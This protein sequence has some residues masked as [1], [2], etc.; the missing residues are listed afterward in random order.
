MAQHSRK[1][2]RKYWPILFALIPLIGLIAIAVSSSTSDGAPLVNTPTVTA[3]SP[4]SGPATGGTAISITGTGFITGATVTIGQGN[5]SVTG[6]ISATGVTVVSPTEITATTGG[7]AKA[8]TWSLFVTTSGGTSAANVGDN[9]TYNAPSAVPTVTAISPNSGPTTGNTPITITGTGFI[10]GA[11]VT[12]GQGSGAVTG[13]IAATSVTVVSSTKITAVTGGGSKAGTWSLFVTTSGGTSAANTSDNFTY[14]TGGV[15]P[16]VTAVSPNS[17]PTAGGTTVTITGTGFVS[18]ATVVIGQGNGTSGALAATVTSTTSTTITATTGGGAKAG[19]F[20]LYVTTPGGTSA[21][22]AGDS[23]SY[24]AA[25]VKVMPLGDSITDGYLTPG[26][27]RTEL[28]QL[29]VNQDHDNISFVGSENSGALAP[30]DPVAS[31][32]EEGHIGWC[33]GLDNSP[34]TYGQDLSSDIV[35]WLNTYQPNIILLHAGT[36]DIASGDTGAQVTTNMDDFLNQ[37]FTTLPKADVLLAKII[38]I[39]NVQ[40]ESN[41]AAMET[42]WQAYNAAI[43]GLVSKYQGLGFNIQLVDMSDVL[44]PATDYATGAANPQDDDFHPNLA[45]YDI[46]AETWYPFVKAL[47]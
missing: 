17:G 44:N 38:P 35:G 1:L 32:N 9:F 4:N 27:Y 3:V 18:G 6:A 2:R 47:Y 34:C 12:I 7:G 29:L 10:T 25:P 33:I 45:G 15:V 36:N 13:A 14:N 28:W 21:G 46:M 23:Y 42:A 37:I 31:G 39:L 8:G 41:Y 40:P 26:G 19:T 5:G 43:P 30:G 20:N 16:T 24:Q 11:T 22:N